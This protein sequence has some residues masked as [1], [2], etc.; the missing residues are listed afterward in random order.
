[1][2]AVLLTGYGGVDKLELREVPEPS[3]GPGELKVRVAAS[4]VNP[5]DW[6]LRSGSYR[7]YSPLELPTI[8]GRDASGEV[9]AAGQGAGRFR[10]GAKVL[11][12]V[13]RAYAE[14]VVDREDAWAGLPA[15]LDLIDAAALPLV[16]LTGTQLIEE[17]V[18]PRPAEVV[19]VT[20]A[21]GSVGRAAVFAAR[22][23]G[24]EVVAGVRARQREEAR[25]LDVDVVALDDEAE[26]ARLPRLDAIAD[27]VG[28]D[29]LQKLIGKV[30]PGGTVG[31]VLGEPAG[32]KERG[33]A[34]RALLVHPDSGQLAALAQ[35]AAAGKLTIPIA[36]RMPLT[37]IREA[38]AL[39]ERG[40]G[41]KIV[42]RNE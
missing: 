40:A 32:A 41:G 35:A 8:L 23:R 28:G 34:V 31:S 10:V 14:Y 27:T 2:R 26:V 17:A 15:G 1:M 19:L 22:S 20:G 7:R 12:F 33:L 18:R 11:G 21:V 3:A 9:V 24:A 30:K 5:I 16:V 39:A 4:S 6:K 29:T 13:R 36:K 25:K 42:L 37:D 38:H